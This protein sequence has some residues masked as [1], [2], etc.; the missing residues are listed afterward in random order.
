MMPGLS[1][2]ETI[3]EMRKKRPG[4]RCLFVTGYAHEQSA[5]LART[6]D[7]ILDKPFL[8]SALLSRV[9]EVLSQ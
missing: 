7:D 6:G 4:L 1:G 5:A 3:T 9:R 8:P 2:P